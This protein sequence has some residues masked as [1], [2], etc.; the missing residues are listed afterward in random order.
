MRKIAA[1]I[2][3]H[4]IKGLLVSIPFAVIIFAVGSLYVFIDKR[5]LGI[6]D[7][8]FG[9]SFPGLGLIILLASLYGI[10]LLA[11][12]IVGKYLFR[13]VEALV[14]RIPLLNTAYKIG[15][16]LSSTLSLPEQ[17]IFKKAVLVEYLKPG[18]WTVGFITGTLT[19]Q[20]N[21]NLLFK[22]YI[23]TPPNP[24]SGTMVLVPETQIRDPGWTVN[25]ALKMVL[26]GGI[27]GPDQIHN[28]Q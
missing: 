21:K 16:Q 5:I 20:R 19:D 24:T 15:K 23:P 3:A 2:R 28:P 26:S 17:Q 14:A 25:E 4:L 11:D 18:I 10:G 27:I 13:I 12:N 6:I 22:I 7:R 8:F 1:H 9:F